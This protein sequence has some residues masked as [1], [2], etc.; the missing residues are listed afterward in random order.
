MELTAFIASGWLSVLGF[1]F[2]GCCSNVFA[3]EHLVREV[4]KSGN[5]ITFAQFL[6]IT[7]IGLPSYIYVPARSFLPRLRARRV[8]L[9]R[10]AVMVG[11]YFLVSVLNNIALGYRISIPLHIVFRSSGLMANMA[12]GYVVMGKRY[13]VKQVVAV[14]MVSVGVVVATLASVTQHDAEGADE[15][16]IGIALLTMG[17]FLAAMLGL[18]QETT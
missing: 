12:C 9:R 8:P 3:L 13:P 15:S 11:L 18:Y 6:F 4:P 7:L 1:I 10:W 2:G 17:V 5:L 14:L 16:L